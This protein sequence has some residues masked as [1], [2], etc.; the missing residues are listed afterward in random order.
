M[1]A[2]AD[3]G[4][5]RRKIGE[6]YARTFSIDDKEWRAKEAAELD[7]LTKRIRDAKSD[8]ERLQAE[9]AEFAAERQ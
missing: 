2:D 4:E 3:A 1:N 7:A 6:A 9:Q 8:R 5:A